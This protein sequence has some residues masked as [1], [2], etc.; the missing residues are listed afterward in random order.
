MTG[1]EPIRL[2]KSDFLEFFSHI[3]PLQIAILWGAANA[4]IMY[5]AI[6]GHPGAGG[7]IVYIPLAFV[8]GIFFW[9]FSEYTLHRWLFHFTPKTPLQERI[10]FLFH[11]I[12]HAQPMVK[13][14]LVMPFPLSIPLASLF[15]GLF[16]LV[17][18]V[19]LNKPQWVAPAFSGFISGYMFYDLGHYAFHHIKTNNS[20]IQYVRKHHMRHHGSESHLRFG[21]SSPLWDYVFGTMPRYDADGKLVN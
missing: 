8:V 12:H 18:S 15:L 7:K 11:G 9:T 14:R 17:C 2:F 10:S 3:H 19:L 5:R 20:Y 21:V 1:K 4:F 13:T 6:T 16:F